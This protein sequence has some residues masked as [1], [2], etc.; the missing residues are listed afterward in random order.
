MRRTI[1]NVSLIAVELTYNGFVGFVQVE[2]QHQEG[3][4]GIR[5]LSP[6]L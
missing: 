1:Q 3:I 6:V 5:S 2:F 4:T